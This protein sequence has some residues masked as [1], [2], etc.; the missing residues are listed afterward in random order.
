MYDFSIHDCVSQC[1]CGYTPFRQHSTAY[2]E[3]GLFNHNLYYPAH[4]LNY[5]T[6]FQIPRDHSPTTITTTITLYINF[7]SYYFSYNTN[8]TIIARLQVHSIHSS[9]LTNNTPEVTLT[10]PNGT[11]GSSLELTLKNTTAGIE[12]CYDELRGTNLTLYHVQANIHSPDMYSQIGNH[13]FTIRL[14]F[15]SPESVNLTN[16]LRYIGDTH[17]VTVDITRAG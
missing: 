14:T 8:A 5:R 6:V 1:P 7:N 13:Y 12:Y 3:A 10:N 9:V 15:Y 17:T 11:E 4:F 2:C 16:N